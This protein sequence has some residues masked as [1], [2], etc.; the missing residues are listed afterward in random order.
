MNDIPFKD[1]LIHG[2]IR[3]ESGRKMSK[4][5]GNGINPMDVIEK[6]GSDSLR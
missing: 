5:L 3:D 2:L 4:S 6:H 1:L